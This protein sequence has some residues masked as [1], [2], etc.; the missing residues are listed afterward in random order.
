MA[1]PANPSWQNLTAALASGDMAAIRSA[2]ALLDEQGETLLAEHIG[3][4][5]VERVRRTARRA[6]E[7]LRRAGGRVI[8][9]HGIMGA[10]LDVV[11]ADGDVDRVWVNYWRLLNGRIADLELRDGKHPKDPSRIVRVAGIFPEYLPLL[12]ELDQFWRV[13]PFAYDW[14]LDIDTAAAELAEL[15]TTWAAGEPCH[16]V[17][18]SM[19]GLVARRFMQRF[20][21]VWASMADPDGRKR[22]GRLI[23]LGTP[24]KGSLAIPMMLAGDEPLVRKLALLDRKHDVRKLLPIL[25]TFPGPYQ[26]LPAPGS[27]SDD[28]DRLYRHATWGSLPAREPFLA[29]GRELHESLAAVQAPEAIVY[30]AGYDRDTPYRIRVTAAG[31]FEYR[32]TRNGDGRVP[33]ELGLLDGVH[34]LWVD[35][36]HGDLPANDAVLTGIHRLLETG[37]TL[38][39]EQ[40][41][42]VTRGAAPEGWVKA[43][44]TEPSETELA[45]LTAG[46]VPTRG[47]KTVAPNEDTERAEALLVAGF[48]G[49][50]RPR[51]AREQTPAGRARSR[52]A[53]PAAAKLAVE[54]VCGDITRVEGDLY[55]VGHYVGVLPQAA[56]LALDRVISP[57]GAP[58]DA[59]VLRMHT[60]RGVLRGELGDVDLYPWADGSG[61]LV[62]IAGMGYPGTFG[63]AELRKLASRL[64]LAV[65]GLPNVRTVCTVLIGSGAGNLGVATCVRR[66]L[67]GVVDAL[68]QEG[69]RGGIERIRIVERSLPKA[70]EIHEAIERFAA[71]AAESGTL[72]LDVAGEVRIDESAHE[73]PPFVVP[74]T[75]ATLIEAAG[76]EP[77]SAKRRA[78]DA[79]L[80]RLPG[81]RARNRAALEAL[82]AELGD[83]HGVL[84]L[85]GRLAVGVR[86]TNAETRDPEAPARFSCVRDADGLVVAALASTAVVPQRALRFDLRLFEELAI[87][88]TDPLDEDAEALGDLTT[89]L[90]IPADFLPL[91]GRAP[92]VVAELDRYTARLPWE[93]MAVDEALDGHRSHLALAV[94]FARQLRTSYAAPPPAGF[95]IPT[96]AA[97]GRRLRALVIGDPGDP[98]TGDDLPGARAEALAVLDIL[99][100]LGVATEARIGAPSAPRRGRLREIEPAGRLEVLKL[101]L[102]GE[103]DLVHYCGHGD[104]SAER[105][106]STGWLFEDGL[107]TA[108]EIEGLQRAPRLIVANA[109][110][111]GRVSERRAGGRALVHRA[112]DETALLPT[113]ADEF[114]KRGVRDYIGTAW[115]VHDEGAVLFAKELYTALL[116]GRA[117]L[118]EALLAARLALAGEE[119]RRRYDALWAAY[120]HYGDPTAAL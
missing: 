73:T 64:A 66:L 92:A 35:E 62:A 111:S 44:P 108:R 10:Q 105:P 115:E 40:T 61:R 71:E 7:T 37:N 24:N 31:K 81:R 107:L 99:T 55:A 68:R 102:C 51:A 75:L 116:A 113:L 84:E 91:L 78:V 85:A 26:M 100:D 89:R 110:L 60:R 104:F 77:Q 83:A 15:V 95:A 109:C 21:A 90:L 12:L 88:A 47:R 72:R 63:A 58:P 54:V 28:R 6:R 118:G 106:D 34:T 9:I 1:E 86:G 52:R 74:M 23:Q 112:A 22:G 67:A 114:F 32:L 30:V 79:V 45:A 65:S 11:A 4:R 19:G 43:M 46:L 76:A 27:A 42:P 38:E 80:A 69:A 103:F 18:H 49:G 94:P 3:A 120:Q 48:V 97:G 33:H 8:V 5:R 96:D 25:G 87:K 29:L 16:I 50:E 13:T 14:R 101:L 57:A 70:A 41:R 82:V 53:A 98:R 20:P 36:V 2:V 56:E 93:L 119:E 117:R 17:A 59:Q 39:L